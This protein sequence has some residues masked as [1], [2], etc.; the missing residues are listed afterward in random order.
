MAPVA[1]ISPVSFS[2]HWLSNRG[3]TAPLGFTAGSA[4]GAIK[5]EG[6]DVALVLASQGT[7]AAAVFTTNQVKAAPV[8]VSAEN[9]A[10]GKAR[11]IIVNAG[12]ANCCTGSRG[13]EGAR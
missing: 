12:N 2:F 6:D 7:T 13:L 3:V 5:T 1:K 8:L 9:L 10:K 11:A 4:R